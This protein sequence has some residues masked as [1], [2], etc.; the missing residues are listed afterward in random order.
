MINIQGSD[1]I[2]E[3]PCAP[4]RDEA[5]RT[6]ACGTRT[7][8]LRIR[9]PGSH[10]RTAGSSMRCRRRSR[11]RTLQE[12]AI[13]GFPNL[14]QPQG[15]QGASGTVAELHARPGDDD[16]AQ[17]LQTGLRPRTRGHHPCR[18]GRH[19]TGTAR[20]PGGRTDR[21]A[22]VPRSPRRHRGERL[23]HPH[24]RLR[25]SRS[26]PRRDPGGRAGAREK[27]VDQRGRHRV[28]LRAQKRH[29]AS[30]TARRSTRQAVEFNFDRML[31]ENHPYHDTGPFPYRSPS[32]PPS[33]TRRRST[34]TR[35]RFT[36]NAP[37]APFLSNLA[38]PTG[39]IVSPDAVK[40]HGADFGRNP[41]R[42]PARSCSASGRRTPRSSSPATRAT[43]KARRR[44]RRWSSSPSPTPTRE[45]RRCSG[46]GRHRRHGG[47][48]AGLG[49]H[50]RR[51]AASCSTSRPARTCGS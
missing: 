46:T 38:Y 17:L 9:T 32:S 42:A 21:R 5:S 22:E 41:I 49:L 15:M 31:D 25:R 4:S 48:P 29:H 8:G 51:H 14:N 44:W 40:K 23:P 6:P 47:D 12:I 30:T 34:T 18:T 2:D 50:V 35:S 10:G 45:W 24:E 26:L 20:C 27:L 28:H 43:G 16:H 11:I 19:R 7:F 3:P 33:R 13:P 36:L 39:L 1:S 37:Y